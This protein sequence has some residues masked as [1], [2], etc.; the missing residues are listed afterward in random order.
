MSVRCLRQD[1]AN[2]TEPPF[3]LH[4]PTGVSVY[5]FWNWDC[6]YSSHQKASLKL[7]LFLCEK[8][9]KTYFFLDGSDFPQW[10]SPWLEHQY[11]KDQVIFLVFLKQ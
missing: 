4:M 10:I 5:F 9:N 3:V 6:D 11:F 8:V 7:A 1:V 2:L